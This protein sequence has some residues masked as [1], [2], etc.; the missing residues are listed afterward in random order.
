[1]TPYLLLLSLLLT[2]PVL[3]QMSTF[4]DSRG[5][6]GM[7]WDNGHGMGMYQDSTGRQGTYQAFGQQGVFQD[8]RGTMGQW[9]TVAPDLKTFQDNKGGQGQLFDFGNGMGSYTYQAPRGTTQGQTFQ[10]PQ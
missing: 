7:T 9:Q 8:N 1:M 4:Q 2:T 5:V 6:I 3:A 10:Y